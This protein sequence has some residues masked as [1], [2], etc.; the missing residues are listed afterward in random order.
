MRWNVIGAA[1]FLGALCPPAPATTGI[2]DL[3][4]SARTANAT[5]ATTWQSLVHQDGLLAIPRGAGKETALA[6][7]DQYILSCDPA[8]GIPAE[9]RQ[10]MAAWIN[11]YHALLIREILR[12]P[13]LASPKSDPGFFTERRYQRAD[14]TRYSLEDLSEKNILPLL[15][16]RARGILH[17]GCYGG[18][19]LPAEPLD[20][21]RLDEQID[22]NW[23]KWLGSPGHFRATADR[24]HLSPIFLWHREDFEADGGFRSVLVRYL[25]ADTGALVQRKDLRV[26]YLPFDWTLSAAGN[27]PRTYT[28]GRML[29]DR[30]WPW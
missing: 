4:V 12:H 5:L 10:Q 19:P 9:G 20:K 2:P 1:L 29:R 28:L 16:W 23:R 3:R 14:G 6:D 21:D 25:P 30:W 26:E 24:I 7:L 13:D 15:G 11:L 27:P 18:P 8:G 22:A 17:L